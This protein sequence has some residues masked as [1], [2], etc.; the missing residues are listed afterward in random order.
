MI[1]PINWASALSL[2][3]YHVI[4]CWFRRRCGYLNTTNLT[5]LKKKNNFFLIVYNSYV[6]VFQSTIDRAG[7]RPSA[8]TLQTLGVRV[9]IDATIQIWKSFW[10]KR[11]WLRYCIT[12]N[13]GYQAVYTVW[14]SKKKILCFYVQRLLLC[15]R[16]NL[17][18]NIN[19]HNKFQTSTYVYVIYMNT[20]LNGHIF[21]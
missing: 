7:R 8:T 13:D 5:S 2:L 11:Y 6:Y 15:I 1:I 20:Y 9:K 3:Y 17:H 21:S 14:E 18:W 12:N 4:V 19:S 16:V 10:Y